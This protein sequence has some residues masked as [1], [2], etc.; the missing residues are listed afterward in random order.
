M[1]KQH[2]GSKRLPPNIQKKIIALGYRNNA[3]KAAYL[4]F[5]CTMESA[6]QLHESG[7]LRSNMPLI[8]LTAGK[9]SEEWK[10]GQKEL[11][12]LSKKTQHIIIEDSWHSIQ[13]HNP[14]SIIDSVIS[15]LN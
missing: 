7:P 11:L 2:I 4:E 8:V 5:L 14:Q 12:N 9:Q 10:E 13:I 3:F 1:I 6:I 15:L